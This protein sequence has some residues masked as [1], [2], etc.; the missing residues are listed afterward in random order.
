MN[1][2]NSKYGF[3]RGVSSTQ[4]ENLSVVSGKGDLGTQSKTS[5]GKTSVFRI[6]EK[7]IAACE[8]VAPP[9][10]VPGMSSQPAQVSAGESGP[11]VDMK[12]LLRALMKY[13]ASDLH[14]KAG[15][16]P[17]YRINGKLVPAKMP[18]IQSN[19]VDCLSLIHI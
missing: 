9:Q 19:Q 12:Y 8:G 11:V 16:P 4:N 2:S 7:K 13:N 5:D 6:E 10:S 14:L 3:N 17:L 15:R 18:Q 1:D